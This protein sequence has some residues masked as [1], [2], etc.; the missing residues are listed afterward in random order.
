[1]KEKGFK[2]RQIR[3]KKRP[4]SHQGR[5]KVAPR[6]PKASQD[7]GKNGSKS[8]ENT[9]PEPPRSNFWSQGSLEGGT[10]PKLTPKSIQN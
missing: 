10:G 7:G 8:D 6:L 4:G 9:G 5:Q 3:K 1:M 2:V